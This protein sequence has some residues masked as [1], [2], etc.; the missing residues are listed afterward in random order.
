ML[1]VVGAVITA[2]KK[3]RRWRRAEVLMYTEWSGEASLKK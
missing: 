3:V 2:I 1:A